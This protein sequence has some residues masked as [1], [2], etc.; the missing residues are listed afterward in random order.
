MI[1]YV[2]VGLKISKY[3]REL[4]MTQDDLADKVFVTR[5]ALSKWENGSSVPS[6]DVLIN[7]SNIFNTNIEDLLCLDETID[8]DKN[9]IF[10]GHSR[11]Y[12]IKNILN[13]TLKIDVDNVLYLLSPQERMM[14]VKMVKENKLKVN[15]DDFKKK[16]TDNELK[17]YEGE[18]NE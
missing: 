6:T 11:E 9:D 7:L 4:N 16:L 3:R 18:K 13:G 15:T 10:K 12:V 5:Q 2:Q 14:V 8:I 1:D 17:F